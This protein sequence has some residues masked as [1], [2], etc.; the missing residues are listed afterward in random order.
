MHLGI[1]EIMLILVVI[2]GFGILCLLVPYWMIFRKA[3]FPPAL[4][5][6]MV[7]PLVNIAMLYFLALTPWPSLENKHPQKRTDPS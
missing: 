2:V 5:L 7:V 3:G 6:L 1:P 4:S